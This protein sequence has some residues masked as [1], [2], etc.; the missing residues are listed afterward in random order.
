VTSNSE[1][2]DRRDLREGGDTGIDLGAIRE[3]R[4]R[5]VM[6]RFAFG[7][8]IATVAGLVGARFGPRAGGLFLAFPAILP[9]ALTF[10]EQ[11]DGES[12]VHGET[13]GAVAGALALVGFASAAA[14]LIGRTGAG[15]ALLA[16][17]A[18]WVVVGVGLYAAIHRVL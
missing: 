9:A 15:V 3:A 1:Q 7:A 11:Q 2:D 10:I 18:V 4:P 17:L 6:V 5:D 16:A 14:L 13:I 8:V 12:A